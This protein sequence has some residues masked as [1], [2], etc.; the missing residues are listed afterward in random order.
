MTEEQRTIVKRMA[1]VIAAYGVQTE[2]AALPTDNPTMKSLQQRGDLLCRWANALAYD[3]TPPEQ[4]DINTDRLC[5]NRMTEHAMT[6][7]SCAYKATQTV[8]GD[9][10]TKLIGQKKQTLPQLLQYLYD[11]S[12]DLQRE[13]A[14]QT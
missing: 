14:L 9:W 13:L 11:R 3:L 1:L 6:A 5:V 2:L 8:P 12:V 7:D 4:L 10:C